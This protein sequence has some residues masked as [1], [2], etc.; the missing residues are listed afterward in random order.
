MFRSLTC[1]PLQVR[2]GGGG[3]WGVATSATYKAYPVVQPS[4]F[5]AVGVNLT[6]ERSE[7]ETILSKLATLAPD[8][9]DSRI[10]GSISLDNSLFAIISVLPQGGLQKLK[11]GMI[12]I[13]FCTSSY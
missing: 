7:L 11:S 5:T 8:L 3:T 4:V 2:G 13:L 9:A 10:G 1:L 6:L 12:H